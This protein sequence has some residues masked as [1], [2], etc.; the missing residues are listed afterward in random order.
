MRETLERVNS[1]QEKI[2]QFLLQMTHEGKGPEIYENKEANGSHGETRPHKEKIFHYHTEGNIFGGGDSKGIT[3][4]IT[5]PRPYLPTFLDNQPQ[6]NHHYEIEDNFK[7]YTREYESLI[8][9][10]RRQVTLDL[11]CGIKFMGKPK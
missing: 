11:Y 8:A 1:I 10:F 9:G 5:T 7:E 3:D 2:V 6:H 4:S